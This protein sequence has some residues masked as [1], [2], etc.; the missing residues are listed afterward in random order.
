[1]TDPYFSSLFSDFMRSYLGFNY[2]Y[3]S[4]KYNE[5][6]KF[7]E[8]FV[9]T[10]YF[11]LAIS[12]AQLNEIKKVRSILDKDVL[13][14]YQMA[15]VFAILKERDSMYYYLDREKDIYNVFKFNGSV[16]AGPY[17]QEARYQAFLKKNYLPIKGN[18]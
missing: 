12:H 8:S 14:N 11:D 17:L 18:K 16:E 3:Y 15:I 2:Q 9:Y 13:K 7:I 10:H 1:M 6:E 4:G 5:A